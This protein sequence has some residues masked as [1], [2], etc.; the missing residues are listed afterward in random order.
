MK[1][2]PRWKNPLPMPM[3]FRHPE[4][5][6]GLSLEIELDQHRGLV[7]HYPPVVPRL[8]SDDLGSHEL[9]DATVRILNIDLTAGQEPDVRV[10]AE[11]RADDRFHIGGPA[12][13][14]RV[15]HTLN[16]TGAGSYNIDLDTADFAAFAAG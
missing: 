15:D 11:I 13:S 8:D 7:S 9:Q 3:R 5:A 4:P 1:R 2:N 16:A 12:K 10:H 14:S 6:D